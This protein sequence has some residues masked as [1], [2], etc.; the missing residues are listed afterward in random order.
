MTTT[1]SKTQQIIE[2]ANKLLETDWSDKDKELVQRI[3]GNLKSYKSFI[4][5]SLKDDITSVLIMA[6]KIKMEYDNLLI[7]FKTVNCIIDEQSKELD[8][9]EK[10]VN[11]I[12]KELSFIEEI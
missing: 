6:N 12:E 11:L 8:L 9:I 4:P 3:V 2:Q 7:K 5:N 10:E 1:I